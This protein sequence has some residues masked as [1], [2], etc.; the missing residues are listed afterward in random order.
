MA[1][2]PAAAS[3]FAIALPI[4]TPALITSAN[5]PEHQRRDAALHRVVPGYE[6][7][8]VLFLLRR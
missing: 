8:L 7:V 1:V 3:V 4:L 2:A 5:R 6:P